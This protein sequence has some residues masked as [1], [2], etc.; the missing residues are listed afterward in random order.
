MRKASS[1]ELFVIAAAPSVSSSEQQNC[2]SYKFLRNIAHT[3][4]RVVVT[5]LDVYNL[6]YT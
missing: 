5:P 4:V 2:S 1:N 6:R 3:P